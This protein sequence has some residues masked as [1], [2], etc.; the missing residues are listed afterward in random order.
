MLSELNIS[1][2]ACHEILREDLRK[3]KPY[4]RLIPYSLNEQQ[5]DDS[6]SICA[7]MLKLQA[8][9]T[10]SAP[11][12][13]LEMKH[14]AYNTNHKQK[15]KAQSGETRTQLPQ[16]NL[17]PNLRKQKQCLLLLST[18]EVQGIRNCSTGSKCKSRCQQR[19]TA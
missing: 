2:T 12:S 13:S 10:Y 16:R 15:D 3:R 19:R 18:A 5:K 6:S 8:R 1:R 9:I 4:A 7:T 14:G 11:P 17:V